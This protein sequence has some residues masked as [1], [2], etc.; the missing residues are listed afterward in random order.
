MAWAYVKS[1]SD[2]PTGAS[3][4]VSVA[5]GSA[6]SA[7]SLLIAAV[8]ASSNIATSD[9]T[10]SV[11]SGSWTEL[12]ATN[13]YTT[14]GLVVL[15]DCRVSLWYRLNTSAGTPTVTGTY[16]SSS[17]G[18]MICVAEYSGIAT[19]GAL[20][21]SGA[22]AQINPG[23][24]TDAVSSGNV[25]VSSTGQ[26]LVVGIIT[27][28]SDDSA[29][30]VGTTFNAARENFVRGTFRRMILEDKNQSGSG[31]VDADATA[32]DTLDDFVS[33][34]AVFNEPAAAAAE[35][36]IRRGERRGEYRGMSYI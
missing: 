36:G 11:N 7:G 17:G 33:I 1:A 18:R 25:S 9:L 16:A 13:G 10:D 20:D 24:G 12:G 8:A 3:T 2:G 15:G 5:F 19:S 31:S 14:G 21:V 30:T 4:T 28:A 6:V 26:S 35:S 22:A 27:N 23:T 34:V 32:A 29:I